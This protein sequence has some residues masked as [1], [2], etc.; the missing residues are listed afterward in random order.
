MLV[1]KDL[2]SPDPII[3][4]TNADPSAILD[5]FLT[6]RVT[7]L[8]VAKQSSEIIGMISEMNLVKIM[9]Q[10]AVDGGGKKLGNYENHFEPATFVD[11]DDSLGNVVKALISSPTHRVLVWN[12]LEKIVGIVSPK[13]LLKVLAKT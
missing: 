10:H 9:V 11:E 1:A 5:V 7:A 12:K 4:Q 13:D 8:P 6:K 2:M 3:V